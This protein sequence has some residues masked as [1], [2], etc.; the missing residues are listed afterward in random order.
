MAAVNI[1]RSVNA[2]LI[3]G[4]SRRGL[5]G[6]ALF[7]GLAG[8]SQSVP[9]GVNPMHVV[10]LG[11]STFDNAVYVPR[12]EA[13]LDKLAAG[14]PPG[15]RAT[16]AAVDGA[17]IGG[18]ERQLQGLPRDATHLIVSVG[19]NDALGAAGV[20]QAR[21]ASVAQA[22]EA[23]AQVRDRFV[24]DYRGMLDRVA[25]LGLPTAIATIY[26]ARFPEPAIRRVAATALTVLNDVITREAALRGLPLVDLRAMFDSDAAYANAIEPSGRG[27]EKIAAAIAALLEHHD[28]ERG[29]ATIYVR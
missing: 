5:L 1:A 29:R 19:G 9:A 22:L 11:D 7:G 6:F 2:A 27:G 23:L 17:V 15:W 25:S 16:L 28:F 18:V 3:P 12:G 26:E 14:L 20:L 4:V 13:V 21:A 8:R 24:E 10:L